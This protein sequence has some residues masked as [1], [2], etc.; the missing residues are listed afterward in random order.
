MTE[1][2]GYMSPTVLD[3]QFAVLHD[4]YKKYNITFKLAGS[5][6]VVN[7]D[8]AGNCKLEMKK[9]LHNGTYADLNV[10]FFPRIFCIRQKRNLWSW[11]TLLGYSIPRRWDCRYRGAVWRCSPRPIRHG[12][13]RT[14]FRSRSTLFGNDTRPRNWSLAWS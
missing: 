5:E 11:L 12:P 1:R 14:R 7:P 3:Q 4:T 8:W 9:A 2:G 10:Y 6:H 13:W